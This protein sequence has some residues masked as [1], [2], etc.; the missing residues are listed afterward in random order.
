MKRR[1]FNYNQSRI[2]Y[3]IESI[4]EEIEK[5]GK[6]IDYEPGYNRGEWELEYNYEYPPDIINEF[7][8]AF[9]EYQRINTV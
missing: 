3:I 2:Q 6:K 1:T 8:N 4:E 9:S 7:K 5:N